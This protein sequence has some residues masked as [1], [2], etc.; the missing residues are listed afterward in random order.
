[1]TTFIY[2]HTVMI[3]LAERVA[4]KCS[5]HCT[6]QFHEFTILNMEQRKHSTFYTLLLHQ[7]LLLLLFSIYI[8]AIYLRGFKGATKNSIV[9]Q[10]SFK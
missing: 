2:D 7:L 9:E 10:M 8:R 1:M 6:Y 3:I 4:L 5:D